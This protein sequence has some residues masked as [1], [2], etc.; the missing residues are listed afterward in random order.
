MPSIKRCIRVSWFDGPHLT[1]SHLRS[2]KPRVSA[3]CARGLTNDDERSPMTTDRV[4]LRQMYTVGRAT[5]T[6]DPLRLPAVYGV[7]SRLRLLRGCGRTAPTHLESRKQIRHTSLDRFAGDVDSRDSEMS[8]GFATRSMR[9]AEPRTRPA[10]VTGVSRRTEGRGSD[11]CGRDVG[12]ALRPGLP[13][14]MR[15]IDHRL[16]G[17]H[18]GSQDDVA[19]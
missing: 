12:P 10:C 11:M 3:V 18:L 16:E 4:A 19:R 13:V 14:A 7:R 17:G 1:A 2:D 15:R 8:S 5:R 6:L 9:A